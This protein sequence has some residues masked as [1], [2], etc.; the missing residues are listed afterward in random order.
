MSHR[1]EK[2][3]KV[4]KKRKCEQALFQA[5]STPRLATWLPHLPR[6]RQGTRYSGNVMNTFKLKL[7]T[8]LEFEYFEMESFSIFRIYG[9]N[10]RS[11]NML[12][13]HISWQHFTFQ[14]INILCRKFQELGALLTAR[15]SGG[16]ENQLQLNLVNCPNNST[17]QV[18]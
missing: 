15:N 3:H 5:A 12:M 10:P 4:S 11:S 2:R 14:N 16:D 8:L 13:A 7:E 1:T 6:C 9:E 18:G 17:L